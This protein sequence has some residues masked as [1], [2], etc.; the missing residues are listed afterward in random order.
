MLINAAH[1]KGLA[2]RAADGELGTVDQ[3]YFDDGSWAIRYLTVDTGGWLGGRQVLISPFSVIHADWH[4]KRLEVALTK[5]QVKNSPDINTHQPVSRQQEAEYN[6]YYGYPYY[7]G[8]P[9]LWGPEVYP[10]GFA[11]G[12]KASVE[13]MA[14]RIERAKDSHLR[15][16][17]AVN[18]YSI[19]AS[20]GDI[21]HVD[22]YVVDD[23]S[24]TI[25][26][27]EVATRNWW[28]GK[29]VLVAPAWIEQVSWADS[30]VYTSLTREAIKGGPEYV[31]SMPVTREYED[32]L[33]SH[34][35]RPPYWLQGAEHL[36]L[37]GV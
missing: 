18:G 31:E 28:P 10:S 33:Y 26:Y 4:A 3:L 8:G 24:W 35:G 20:N 23:Q 22:G 29:K 36:S 17:G 7:W 37:S 30:K 1:L 25:R 15:S 12:T 16:S 32:R 11:L 27:I 34:Y 9:Y 2:I 21:G 6:L 19:E 14:E 13:A 5:E